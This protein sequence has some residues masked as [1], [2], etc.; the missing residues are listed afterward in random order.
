MTNTPENKPIVKGEFVVTNDRGLH[1]RPST[2][3][4][5]CASKFLSKI[6]LTYQKQTVNA[7][8]LLSVLILAAVRGA[9]IKIRAEGEDA[10]EAV[11]AIIKLASENFH[12]DY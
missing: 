8:S 1:T 10:K 2:E 9:K 12:S 6:F 3:L 11:E 5:R 4:V 7:K